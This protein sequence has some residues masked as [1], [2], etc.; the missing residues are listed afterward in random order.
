MWG[1]AVRCLCKC[2]VDM[3]HN[4]P[5][6]PSLNPHPQQCSRI[7]YPFRS[8]NAEGKV[9][10]LMWG[11]AVRCLYK[12]VE[13]LS[14]PGWSRMCGLSSPPANW[15]AHS[16]ARKKIASSATGRTATEHSICGLTVVARASACENSTT[17]T[18]PRP[19][20]EPRPLES[21]LPSNDE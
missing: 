7:R 6:S 21:G 20:S 2:E 14:A 10:R 9:I 15:A 17:K 13:S 8:G 3:H 18:A 16:L 11:S 12:S 1:S 4:L 5:G 19:H